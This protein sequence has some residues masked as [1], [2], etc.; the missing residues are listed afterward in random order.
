MGSE[1]SSN[2][3]TRAIADLTDG[4]PTWRLVSPH[5]APGRGNAIALRLLAAVHRLVPTGEAPQ[6][7]PFYAASGGDA[8]PTAAW[9][10]VRALLEDC[11]HDLEPLVALGHQTNEPGCASSLA[12][13]HLDVAARTGLPIA[14]TEIGTSAG[15]N[16]RW[17]RFRYAGGG[18]R[19][20]DPGNPVD[21]T[22]SWVDVPAVGDV[23]A[24]VIPRRGIDRF[25]VDAT[26]REGYL[27]LAS[28]I[29]GDQAARFE[30]LRGAVGLV[31]AEPAE[32]LTAD[33]IEWVGDHLEPI[34]LRPRCWRSRCSASTSKGTAAIG[35]TTRSRR[36]A[37]VQAGPLPWRGSS[38]S[39]S[40][41]SGGTV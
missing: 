8:D 31:R 18:E 14:L 25:P 9:P 41:G 35:W 29:W 7:Q 6:L 4:G 10:H 16:L 20:G 38:W 19:W 15:L 39:R 33:A 5:V 30:R 13:G 40:T 1:L 17:D 11:G 26:T 23:H 32:M 28:S 2:L 36:Q 34:T 21:L 27:A 12:I 24:P 22:G 3:L 37:P